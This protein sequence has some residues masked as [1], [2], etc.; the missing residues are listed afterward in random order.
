MH[1]L[2]HCQLGHSAKDQWVQ[3]P[4]LQPTTRGL[5]LRKKRRAVAAK[6]KAQATKLA[7]SQLSRA[8]RWLRLLL[9]TSRAADQ[10]RITAVAPTNVA[11]TQ[12][13]K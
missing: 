4:V 2:R 13:S 6:V 11:V 9:A 12:G 5:A 10:A 3:V 1:E 8:V 7:G